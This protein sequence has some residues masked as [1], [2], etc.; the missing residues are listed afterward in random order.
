MIKYDN[1]LW[2]DHVQ[3]FILIQNCS[4]EYCSF[5]VKR[6]RACLIEII[7]SS[8]YPIQCYQGGVTFFYYTTENCHEVIQFVVIHQKFILSKRSHVR[9]IVV[10]IVK[11]IALIFHVIST[12]NVSNMKKPSSYWHS[13]VKFTQNP[14]YLSLLKWR[15]SILITWTA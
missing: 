1:T 11:T 8:N 10:A 9:D 14:I 6:S 5:K 3:I 2:N 4:S 13:T 12:L 15:H 7:Q